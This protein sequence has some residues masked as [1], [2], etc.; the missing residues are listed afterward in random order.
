MKNL[1]RRKT[2]LTKALSVL[3]WGVENK[4]AGK[5][6]CQNVEAL[7]FCHS[8]DLKGGRISYADTEILHCR[9]G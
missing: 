8:D 4:G 2:F 6:S 5:R 7:S 1:A 9:S 3:E